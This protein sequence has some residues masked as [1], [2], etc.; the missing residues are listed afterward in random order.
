MTRSSRSWKGTPP[1]W[2]PSAKLGKADY[3]RV[4]PVAPVRVR[5]MPAT[6]AEAPQIIMEY[7][8]QFDLFMGLPEG[9]QFDGTCVF[10]GGGRDAMKRRTVC[11]T[12]EDPCAERNTTPCSRSARPCPAGTARR[13]T[14]SS[15]PS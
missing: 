2:P 12:T 10:V 8:T 9:G 15:W 14:G 11:G 3:R 5:I 4:G 6:P 7:Q 13:W 1:S